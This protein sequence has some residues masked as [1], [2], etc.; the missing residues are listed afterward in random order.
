MALGIGY[1]KT[2]STTIA[3]VRHGPTIGGV[4]LPVRYFFTDCNFGF[5]VKPWI[6]TESPCAGLSPGAQ[7]KKNRSDFSSVVYECGGDE[8]NGRFTLID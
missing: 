4:G 2:L 5:L 8:V 3:F 1:R 6:I 7:L